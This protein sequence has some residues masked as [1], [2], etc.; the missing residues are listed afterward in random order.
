MSEVKSVTFSENEG[1]INNQFA[2]DSA[3]S[4]GSYH[5]HTMLNTKIQ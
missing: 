3:I 4:G 1:F 2:V 5:V